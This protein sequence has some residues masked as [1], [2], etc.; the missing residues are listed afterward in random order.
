MW[1]QLVLDWNSEPS[2]IHHILLGHWRVQLLFH[3]RTVGWM[4]HIQ[5]SFW[6]SSRPP[7]SA[8]SMHCGW[9]Q[10]REFYPWVA[11]VISGG[12]QRNKIKKTWKHVISNQH[13]FVYWIKFA[14][15]H[16]YV[17]PPHTVTVFRVTHTQG[18]FIPEW[19]NCMFPCCVIKSINFGIIC[20][21]AYV[22]LK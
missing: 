2:L 15:T 7:C 13:P 3:W 22:S 18:S 5:C 16:T 11:K 17:F 9:M 8:E 10:K 1:N 14:H 4:S 6:S 19:M 12:R 20:D 21:Q